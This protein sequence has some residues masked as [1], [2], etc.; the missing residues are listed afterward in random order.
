MKNTI[1]NWILLFF[2]VILLLSHQTNTQT[3]TPENKIQFKRLTPQ[4]GFNRTDIQCLF[5]DSKG[6]LWIS[7]VDWLIRFDGK[8]QKLFE[9]STTDIKSIGANPV[10]CILEDKSGVLWFGTFGGGLNKYDYSEENFIRYTHN[11]QNSSS[12]S[13]ND[14]FAIYEDSYGIFWAG[15]FGG[16]LNKFDRESGKFTNYKNIPGDSTSLSQNKVWSIY[17]DSKGNLWIGTSGGG[18]N[19][20]DRESQ[21]FIR[22]EHNKSNLSSISNNNITDICEDA[23]G[24]L[25]VSTLGGGLNKVVYNQ[26]NEN[27]SFLHYT[28]NPDDP[29]SLSSNNIYKIYLDRENIFWIGTWGAGLNK[30]ITN[31][32]DTSPLTFIS[33]KHNPLDIFSLWA[34]DV[35]YIYEDN[36]GVLW[37]SSWGAGLQIFDKNKKLF[38][39]YEHEPNN[40]NSLSS[41]AVWSVFE[42][43]EGTRWIGTGDGGLNK[44]IKGS[45]KFISYKNNPSNPYSLSDN[46]VSAIYED[47]LDNL[48]VGTWNG[49]LNKFDRKTGRFYRYKHDPSNPKSISEDRI[50]SL[51]EDSAGNLW[52]G[53]HSRGL[54][55]FNRANESFTNYTHNPENPSSI[56]SD[57]Q[58]SLFSNINGDLY[59]ATSTGLDSYDQKNNKFIHYNLTG[60]SSHLIKDIKVTSVVQSKS[61]IIWIGT[62]EFGLIKYDPNEGLKKTY[63][64]NDGL[65]VNYISGILEDD[66]GNLWVS[67]SVGVSN[68]NPFIETIK[69]YNYEDGI[70]G[71]GEVTPCRSRTGEMIFGSYLGLGIFHPDS[72][73]DYSHIP[74]VYFTD[75]YLFNKKVPIG[76]DSLTKRTILSQSIIECNGIVLNHD[77]NVLSFDFAIIDY[78]SLFK[79]NQFAYIMEG[80]DKNWIYSNDDKRSITYTNLDPGEYTLRVKAANSDNI[81]NEKGASLRIIILPPWWATTWAYILYTILILSIIYFTWKLQLKRLRNKHELEMSR[82][83]A[84]KLHEV[85]EIKSRFFTNISHEFRTPL[86]LILGPVKQAIDKIKDEKT[87]D[88]LSIAHKNA[89]KLLE[90]VSQLLD[91]S[92][93]ES[94]N[95]KLR[96]HPLNFAALLKALT[97]SFASYAERKRITLEFNSSDDEITVYA[98]KDKIEKIFTNILS[99]AFKFTPEGGRIEVTVTRYFSSSA[100]HSHSELDSESPSEM[101]KLKRVQLNHSEL[102]KISISD[103]GIGIPKEKISKIFDRFYQ[104][105]GSHTREQEGTGIGL[106]L[107]KEL[108]ELHKGK[109]E[110]E[111]EEGKGTIVTVS[112]LLGKAHLKPEEISEEKES[113]FYVHKED[114]GIPDIEKE[115]KPKLDFEFL[116]DETLPL[117]LIAEDNP[118][119]RNYI[120]DNLTKEFRTIE[121][122]DGEDGWNKAIEEMPDLIVSDVMMP[123]M[124]GFK[125]CEKLKTDE[126]TSHIP[127]IL[128]TA[129]AAKEDKLEGYGLGADEYLMK[130]F[131]PKELEARIKN[132]IKQ[133]QRL[134]EH[135]RNKGIVELDHDKISSIDEKFLRRAFDLIHQNISDPSFN[136]EAFGEKMG[137]SRSVL[138][139]KI[140]S[141]AGEPPVEFIRRIRLSYATKLIEKKFGNL[142]EISLE[143]GFNNPAYFS[144][145]FKKQFG[146]TPSHFQRKITNS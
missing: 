50:Y 44:M 25:W 14:V 71:I 6:F 105:D 38:K 33:Y 89:N 78:H 100:G 106:A 127:I 126:R 133:R 104:V 122:V 56:N 21:K 123:K 31:F 85:D 13:S 3:R 80:F 62:R 92:K 58:I 10:K 23:Y 22:Y 12:I 117:L 140:V 7:S 90:L 82:F 60:N 145:C 120:K 137:M 81:W 2:L 65:P 47:K 88:D 86:T 59:I 102:V 37:V 131:E 130:P 141:L 57:F 98:D 96:A 111:S 128:L 101:K 112:I 136:V 132:L 129:K 48:W 64:K 103:S 41:T 119:V 77:D 94:G 4:M 139:K 121:A 69:T 125:L 67:T 135:F 66:H 19:I 39:H 17:E 113:E 108:V 146:I 55:K 27:Y 36:S 115:E 52:I 107:T 124:D 93:L 11:N 28:H 61:G 5:Q 46:C 51:I 91:I 99:N 118:D 29:F 8:K 114:M 1:P 42:D 84:Q 144:E 83:E 95:M 35:A 34:N 26:E 79:G 63:T 70:Q 76:Y 54:N 143:V 142:S 30:M 24:N 73:R 43:R 20:F 18:I 32:K 9:Y 68:F 75:L 16:G 110:V 45:D 40:P 134:H 49:G 97:L 87:K 74:L 53:T 109:I 138:H 72:I 116:A 15:T